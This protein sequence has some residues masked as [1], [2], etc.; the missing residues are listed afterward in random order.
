MKRSFDLSAAI[1]LI[2]IFLPFWIII[3]IL[4]KID[5]PGS[6]FFLQKRVGL[7]D[8]CFNIIKFRSMREG[9]A[10]IP[11]E[12]LKDREKMITKVGK[13]LRRF[14]IDEFPQLF[15]IL[16]GDMSFVGPRPSH[17][18]Q[19]EQIRLRKELGTDKVRPG[20][21]GLA[22]VNGRDGITIPEKAEFDRIYVYEYKT[23][24]DFKIFLKTVKVVLTF[25]GGN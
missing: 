1:I 2:I 6:I 11:A 15:N 12:E 13:F 21:T 8:R 22:Q 20:L 18:G 19:V 14:S 9:T 17:L 25:K 4:I 5:S 16:R 3:P 10:D 24:M 23:F 7:N